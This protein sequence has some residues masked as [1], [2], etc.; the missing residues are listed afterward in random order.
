MARAPMNGIAATPPLLPDSLSH[1]QPSCPGSARCSLA[2]KVQSAIAIASG[3]V[4]EPRNEPSW[5]TM[6]KLQSSLL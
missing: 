4:E 6:L 3:A 2:G 1:S 5:R